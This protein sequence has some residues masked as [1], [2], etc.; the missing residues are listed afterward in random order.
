MKR[1]AFD[2]VNKRFTWKKEGFGYSSCPANKHCD[3]TPWWL[4]IVQMEGSHS[5]HTLADSDSRA[6][7]SFT[8]YS[9][10]SLPCARAVVRRH[11]NDTHLSITSI[12][13]STKVTFTT[14]ILDN[15]QK[16]APRP[17]L[18]IYGHFQRVDMLYSSVMVGLFQ[19]SCFQTAWP[20]A[21]KTRFN[22]KEKT[23]TNFTAIAFPKL[24]QHSEFDGPACLAVH[25][26]GNY[27]YYPQI[28]NQM[29]C[30]ANTTFQAFYKHPAARQL[31][32]AFAYLIP[33]YTAIVCYESYKHK[34]FWTRRAHLF[35]MISQ[36]ISSGGTLPLY[37]GLLHLSESTSSSRTSKPRTEEIWSVWVSTV[38]GCLVPTYLVE[39]TD[40]QY[41][42]MTFWHNFPYAV[43]ILNA[44]LPS[45]FRPIVASTSPTIPILGI[46]ATSV[47]IS[48]RNH[49]ALI[50][51]GFH[52]KDVY[53]PPRSSTTL[54]D[55]AHRFGIFDYSFT[56]LAISMYVVTKVR[57]NRRMGISSSLLVFLVV[58]GLAGPA[59]AVAVLWA[60]AEL[61]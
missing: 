11:D 34:G 7:L 21:W 55:D 52:W 30:L 20:V 43:G 56:L 42:V 51:T 49:L 44:C 57:A 17:L 60:Q 53:L 38:L 39:R 2:H 16:W 40:M 28:G 46:M 50:A 24:V 12:Y 14:I 36:A 4:S 41:H 54:T 15:N 32:N 19:T 26:E 10:L 3:L 5:W 29:F 33:V 6:L 25:P 9:P 22:K 59:A 18:S 58:T 31:A 47:V 8:V 1:A 35:L 45:L 61:A 13:N 23:F 27:R 48:L 37:L